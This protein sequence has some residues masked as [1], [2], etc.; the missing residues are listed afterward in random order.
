MIGV[1]LRKRLLLL[2]NE[3]GEQPQVFPYHGCA[4][5]TELG[6]QVTVPQLGTDIVS[7]TPMM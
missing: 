1:D 3:R 6:G 7:T 5:P 4:L 2:V